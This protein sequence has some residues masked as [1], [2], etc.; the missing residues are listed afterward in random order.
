MG[1]SHRNG[2]PDG[3]GEGLG[4]GFSEDTGAAGRLPMPSAGAWGLTLSLAWLAGVAGQLQ[5]P[6]LW[7]ASAYAGLASAALV[8]LLLCIGLAAVGRARGSH[9]RP[10]NALRAAVPILACALCVFALGF[11]LAAW[12]AGRQ[13]AQTLPAELEGV[14]FEVVGT[15]S[16][17]PR[18]S[19]IG[20][21]FLF[22]VQS[23]RRDGRAADLPR[24]LSLGWYGG[25]RRASTGPGLPAA[26]KAG[27]RW[28]MTVRLKRPHGLMNPHGF[29]YE[30]H[31]FEQGV[32]A[33][34]YVRDNGARLLDPDAGHA[35]QRLRQRVKD[36]IE[37]RVGD[38][39]AAGLLAGLSVGDQ[40]AIDREDWE[41]FRATGVAHLVSISGLHVTMFAWLA[42]AI[43]R[44]LWRRSARAS[45]WWPAPAAALWG[46]LAAAAAYALFSGW[47][48]PAQRT[49]WMLSVATLLR[50][51]GRRWPWPMVLLAAAVAVTALDPWAL[52]Q[53]GF[54]LSF[55]AV[56]LLMASGPQ[57]RPDC[58]DPGRAARFGQAGR[59]LAGAGAA[60][61]AGLRTQVI[62]TV[63]LAP[64]G[65]VFFQQ[66]SLVGLLAN[67]V[68]IPVVSFA[69]T[70]LA[71]AGA[72]LPPLWGPAAWL[73]QG[74]G[75]YLSVLASWPW[76]SWTVAAA[77][78][79]AQCAALLGAALAALPLP[80]RLRVLALPLCLPLCLPAAHRPV[81]GEFEL[82]AVDVGQGTAVLVRTR[83]H[84]LLFDS[85][86][87]YSPESDAG[88]RVLL[89]LLQARGERRIDTLMISHSDT[90][91]VGGA[92]TL[93]RRFPIASLSSS[94]SPDHPLQALAQGRGVPSAP[95][96]AGQQW[97]WDGVDF[98]VL[99][100]SEED[101]G[102]RH[103]PNAMSCVLRVSAASGGASAL[104]TGDIER[105]QESRLVER[106]GDALRS[107][108]LLVPHHGSKTSSTA[109][110]L[111]SVRADVA[112]VQSGYRNRFGHPAPEVVRRLLR[113]TG[114]VQASPS[115][116]AWSW[117]SGEAGTGAQGR[118]WREQ[119]RR[120]WHHGQAGE[121]RE[122]GEEGR[123]AGP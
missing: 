18:E 91:H 24:R 22:D 16:S 112:V 33:T 80:R 43:I 94:L 105:G 88:Q 12:H 71:L 41:I 52:L 53:P 45:L 95:C 5:Q 35:V 123:D 29:D 120:Y 117:S 14:D 90:D 49:V 72:L 68:A 62:A 31:L 58:S 73:A 78:P 113:N 6:R 19:T 10:G 86:P 9:A 100:P 101:Y 79:W 67:L 99:H 26:F 111:G 77:A 8:A 63:G 59:W 96:L 64:L 107:Q 69:L 83:G 27:Q 65:L 104:L 76:A 13:L 121:A 61:R 122:D 103:K 46:G 40:S 48:V 34:G 17:L 75:E 109:A 36:A 23:A 116:G 115:C 28:S 89:P 55:A 32:G 42:G 81:A 66:V 84:T 44:A 38:A 47:G 108:V 102:A 21:R 4:A 11:S 82:L 98:Q 85:G 106:Y 119:A 3:A 97:R 70:P 50:T 114:G 15:V 2:V 39:R 37:A 20:T 92:A 51:G 25:A 60:A 118:C 110:F 93:L 7:A 30:L 74:L 54:W 56:G 87:Q 57:A 1:G